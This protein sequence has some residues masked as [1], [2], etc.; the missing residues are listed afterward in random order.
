M[1][2][3]CAIFVHFW[4]IQL[5]STNLCMKYTTLD[6]VRPARDATLRQEKSLQQ[7]TVMGFYENLSNVT[8]KEHTHNKIS[9]KGLNRSSLAVSLDMQET[10]DW[11]SY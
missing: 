9:Y 2:I 8:I 7:S 3:F 5:R 11:K 10:R 1:L 6:M 4:A